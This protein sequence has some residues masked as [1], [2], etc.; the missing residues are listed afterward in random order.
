MRW[1]A[2]DARCLGVP[3]RAE[4]EGTHLRLEKWLL[5]SRSDGFKSL[6]SRVLVGNDACQRGWDS[7]LVDFVEEA[8]LREIFSRQR[9]VIQ[10][11]GRSKLVR[12]GSLVPTRTCLDL[13]ELLLI[14][15]N[16]DFCVLLCSS[17]QQLF[18]TVLPLSRVSSGRI[19]NGVD[20][21]DS[22]FPRPFVPL[23]HQQDALLVELG[24]ALINGVSQ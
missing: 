19:Q 24:D 16:L 12:S 3:C 8:A 10:V 9:P 4:V 6:L 15:E 23:R 17:V 22:T 14:L 21:V 13:H 2:S 20:A 7:L 1:S 5:W 18:Q 11:Q